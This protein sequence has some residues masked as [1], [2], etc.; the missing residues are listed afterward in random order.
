MNVKITALP[1]LY[2]LVYGDNGRIF[3]GGTALNFAVH[4]SEFTGVDVSLIGAVGNDEFGQKISGAVGYRRICT[5]G[6]R[7]DKKKATPVCRI[8][9][10]AAKDGTGRILEN[11]GL[12]DSFK[13]SK[14]DMKELLISD[15][16]FVDY[17]CACMEEIFKLKEEYGFKLAVDFGSVSDL[18]EV[19]KVCGSIDF[20]L[21]SGSD[22][23][24]DGIKAVSAKNPSVFNVM[25]GE[26]GSLTAVSGNVYP[27]PAAE[28]DE[29][30]DD[31]GFEDCYHAAFI[32]S[33]M[34]DH[35]IEKAMRVASEMA[36]IACE[37]RGGF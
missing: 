36:A 25:L 28:P 1:Q 18:A 11:T 6:I 34:V 7:T 30:I 10:A 8:T 2:A 5:D 20:V 14:A 12:L 4:A 26:K 13:L 17:G 31:I 32:C 33:Y 35:S 15:L 27:E 23:V 22:A 24:A 29:F 37:H 16:V 9:D 19:E 3:P 21:M